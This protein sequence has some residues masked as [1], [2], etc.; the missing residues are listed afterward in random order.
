MA[1]KVKGRDCL[2]TIDAVEHP[3]QKYIAH[4]FMG[5]ES[6]GYVDAGSLRDL[7]AGCSLLISGD[8][9]DKEED[10]QPEDEPRHEPEEKKEDIGGDFGEH[11]E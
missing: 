5:K 1:R 4:V 8:D 3:G 7:F 9:I 6:M 2:F 11:E 10:V